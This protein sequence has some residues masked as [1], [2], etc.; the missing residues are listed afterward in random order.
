M[1]QP[2]S[3]YIH[4]AFCK[5]KCPYCDFNSHVR[6]AVDDLVWQEALL[7]EMQYYAL[8][9]P[10]RE[11][12]SIFFGG[13]TPSLMQVSTVAA[14]IEAASKY[15][16]FADDIEITL[17][18]NPTSVEAEK[19]SGFN[20]A[21]VNRVSIGVQS[22]NEMDLKF[23]GR[24]HSSKQAITAIE[25]AQN[26]FPRY[27]FDLIYALPNQTLKIWEQELTT[28]IKYSNKHLSLYQ[29]TIEEN[30]AFHHI[31]HNGGFVLPKDNI[32]A[33]MYQLT[34]EITSFYEIPAYEIS[35]YA[36]KGQE[37]RHNLAYWKSDDYIGIGAGAHGR[38]KANK[39][40]YRIATEN[41][42]SPERWLEKIARDN[43]GLAQKNIISP[44]ESFD[45]AIMM[46]LR[47]C[48]GINYA[49]WQNRLGIDIKSKLSQNAIDKL[50]KINLLEADE[51]SIKTSLQGKILLNSIIKEL[52]V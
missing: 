7:K 46:G 48:D 27:S 37:S 41:I 14:L 4:W 52:L 35:N 34:G 24:E 8:K 17:E 5:S 31:Y 33:D 19:F 26:I 38:F 51:N 49:D 40:Q 1:K 32:A 2:L 50:C 3:L 9:L 6:A 20:K 28:A 18:A 11:L 10:N 44:E 39:S 36:A 30:T 15:W 47:L 12:V 16:I 42:K 21:G 45:E 43:N 13:G 25:L 22:F 23:L 29:L